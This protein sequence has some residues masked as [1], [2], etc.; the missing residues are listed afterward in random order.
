MATLRLLNL[1]QTDGKYYL[2]PTTTSNYPNSILIIEHLQLILLFGFDEIE[3]KPC[4]FM[5][6]PLLGYELEDRAAMR[7]SF[8]DFDVMN[9]D[10]RLSGSGETG[11]GNKPWSMESNFKLQA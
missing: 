6:L 2:N 1:E 10:P 7:Q 9:C 5:S 4:L 8:L 11:E 3:P